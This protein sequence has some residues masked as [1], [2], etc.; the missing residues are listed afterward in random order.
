MSLIATSTVFNKHLK[1]FLKNLIVV[2]P[3]DR[4][5]KKISSALNI[6]MMDDPEGTIVTNFYN[7]LAP[8]KSLIVKRDSTLFTQNPNNILKH[9]DDNA[10][11][12]QTDLIKKMHIYWE[13][14]KDE[15]KEIVWDHIA[16]L[17]EVAT[18][19]YSLR[20]NI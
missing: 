6:A 11:H 13:V 8:H 10:N 18:T 2:F 20:S 9:C 7:M 4:E 17:F 3:E 1:D 15:N 14:L 5:V 16:G 12:Y 19:Y